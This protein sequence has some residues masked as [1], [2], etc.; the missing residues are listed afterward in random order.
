MTRLPTPGGD[1]GTW[2]NILNDFLSQSHDSDGT[3]KDGIVTASNLNDGSITTQKLAASLQ[4]SLAKADSAV[5]SVNSQTPTA[6]DVSLA[7]SDLDDVTISS[8]ANGHVLTYDSSSTSWKNQT[9]AVTS[10][11]G[12]T[13]AITGAQIANDST[14]SG[15]FAPVTGL[16]GQYPMRALAYKLT[17]KGDARSQR[18][19]GYLLGPD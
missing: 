11:V 16:S 13:G 14:I 6:G 8:L 18:N 17:P 9:A 4:T 1:Q 5:Q 10:V 19:I 12:Q 3:L 2:G 7:L 15:S